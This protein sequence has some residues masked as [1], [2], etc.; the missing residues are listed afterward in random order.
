VVSLRGVGRIDFCQAK[1]TRRKPDVNKVL[2]SQQQFRTSGDVFAIVGGVLG[3]L[4]T[5]VDTLS[6]QID[7]VQDDLGANRQDVERLSRAVRSLETHETVYPDLDAL[8]EA[9]A[10]FI[11][12]TG[13]Q[14]GQLQ[15]ILG[16][17][18]A[19][20]KDILL[21]VSDGIE[22]TDRAERRIRQTIQR[23]RKSL[24]DHGLVDESLEAEGAELRLLDGGTGD[25]EEMPGVQGDMEVPGSDEPSSIPGV[26]AAALARF[27]GR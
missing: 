7:L 24:A 3:R 21:A 25:Y 11:G 15:A 4:K 13:D 12:E 9:V 18:E 1:R 22:R 26:T 14:F 5:R 2:P 6:G 20:K 8:R 17:L 27:Y 23:A 19:W 16:G 10:N